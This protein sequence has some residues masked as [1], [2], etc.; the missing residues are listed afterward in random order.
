VRNITDGLLCEIQTTANREDGKQQNLGAAKD[1]T[2]ATGEVNDMLNPRVFLTVLCVLGAAMLLPIGGGDSGLSPVSAAG[3]AQGCVDAD[4]DKYSKYNPKWC[5][6][7]NDPDDSDPCV[8]PD[9]GTPGSACDGSGGGS[10]STAPDPYNLARASFATRTDLGL[11]ELD[12]GVFADEEDHCGPFDYWDWQDTSILTEYADD[13]EVGDCSFHR[14]SSNVS[15]GGRW[16][17]ISGPAGS[18]EVLDVI[19]RW[20]VVDFSLPV[21]SSEDSPCYDLDNELYLDNVEDS[22]GETV[23]QIVKNDDDCVDNLAIRLSA[24]RILKAKANQQQLDFSIP[25]RPDPDASIYWSPWGYVS[26]IN[27]L[28]LREPSAGDP[29]EWLAAGCRVMSTR[30]GPGQGHNRDEAELLLD[31]GPGQ[32]KPLGTYHLPMEVCVKRA[33]D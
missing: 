10:G 6:D 18:D 31:I 1:G 16:F 26:W 20:L 3:A 5:P 4:D 23:N 15:G 7:G 32:T 9:G 29:P 21:D 33:S 19:E 2:C 28:Y 12:G 8:V 14:N 24:D 17:L 11:G 25:W 30:P 13:P 27:P 22:Q